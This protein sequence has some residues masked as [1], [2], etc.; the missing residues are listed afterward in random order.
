[1]DIDVYLQPFKLSVVML[2][3]QGIY[4]LFI[5]FQ[6]LNGFSVGL[7]QERTNTISR[8]FVLFFLIS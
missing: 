3:F 6:C 7:Y 8:F 1:M 2:E 5:P 4:P